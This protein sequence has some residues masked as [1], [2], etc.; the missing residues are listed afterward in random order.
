MNQH[1]L[2]PQIDTLESLSENESFN[3][4]LLDKHELEQKV[5][6][7]TQ[8]IKN[9]LKITY[10]N[11][12]PNTITINNNKANTINNHTYSK[13]N[14]HNRYIISSPVLLN[15]QNKLYH[16]KI[17][18]KNKMTYCINIDSCN[19]NERKYYNKVYILI[20]YRMKIMK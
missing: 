12:R 6:N 10:G 3:S 7:W 17:V 20:Y 2:Y 5:I 14:S 15:K 18:N 1:F 11:N 16:K 9:N 8:M 13:P 4:R 19:S